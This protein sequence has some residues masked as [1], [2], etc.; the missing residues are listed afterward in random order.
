VSDAGG[1]ALWLAD[2]TLFGATIGIGQMFFHEGIGFK[3]NL[4]SLSGFQQKYGN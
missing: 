2:Y 1:A 3:Y 4:V